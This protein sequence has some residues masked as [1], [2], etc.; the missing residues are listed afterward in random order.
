VNV[1][2]TMKQWYEKTFVRLSLAHF[3]NVCILLAKIK[4]LMHQRAKSVIFIGNNY[5]SFFILAT[6]LRQRG[7]HTS[8][9]N[10]DIGCKFVQNSHR[11]VRLYLFKDALPLFLDILFNYQFL[12][13][14]NRTDNAIYAGADPFL[15]EILCVKNL[16][17]CGVRVIFSPSG[18]LNGS[19][20]N[21]INAI[22]GGLCNKCIWQGNDLVCND[23]INQRMIDWIETNCSVYS[24]EVDHP[25]RLSKTEIGFNLPLSPLDSREYSENLSVPQN[26]II[27]KKPDELLIMTAFANESTRADVSRGRDI[28]GKKYILDAIRRLKSEG[29]A[30][31]HFHASDVP[32]KNMKYYQ[33][34]ADIIVDQLNYGSIGSASR[35]GMMLA[36]PVVCF[37]SEHIRESNISMKDCPAI[38]ANEETIYGV[39]KGLL[40]AKENERRE[41]G[42]K[43][44][45]W[46]LKWFDADVCASRYEKLANAV[47]N[48]RS[49]SPET[50]FI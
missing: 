34:Q 45:R 48:K 15:K 22:T 16:R 26:L 12:H 3:I 6:A 46:M 23:S 37:I 47:L 10:P 49:L 20:S 36:K 30:I 2:K 18:C 14:Y 1:T 31:C 35:E 5:N 33:S 13:V 19:T 7:W 21:E 41:I 50:D 28:K 38:S 24:N 29:K 32:V 11:E 43:S 8:S 42:E 4:R 44:R 9:I 40:E 27:S 39:L 17:K 25:K